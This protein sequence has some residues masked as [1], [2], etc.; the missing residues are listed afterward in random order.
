L[1]VDRRPGPFFLTSFAAL[2]AKVNRIFNRM[3]Q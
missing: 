1:P 3:F 2:T